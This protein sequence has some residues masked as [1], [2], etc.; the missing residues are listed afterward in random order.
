[1][2][3]HVF[4]RRYFFYGTQLAVA[5]PSGGFGSVPSP[6]GGEILRRVNTSENVVAL[7]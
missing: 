2:S 4:S 1:M 3:D 6:Q 7:P 5:V